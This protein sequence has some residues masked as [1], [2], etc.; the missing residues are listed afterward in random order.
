M[1]WLKSWLLGIFGA[2]IRKELL[3]ARLLTNQ[4]F[5]GIYDFRRWSRY[6]DYLTAF[7]GCLPAPNGMLVVHPGA[8]EDWR[9]Q[10][11]SALRRFA[12]PPGEPHRF[13][14]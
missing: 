5:A 11:F 14:R 6:P 13:R 3:A 7:I 10:E 8:E 4:G 9:R 12:F 1:P 2:A